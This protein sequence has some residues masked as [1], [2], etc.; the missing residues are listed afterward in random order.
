MR[1]EEREAVLVIFYLL[2]GDGPA[3]DGV[4]LLAIRTHLSAMH[5][6][7]LVAIR[8]V[9]S[10]ILEDRLY[11]ASN[12]LH[13]LVHSAERVICFVVIKFRNCPNWPPTRSCVTVLTRYC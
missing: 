4:A 1:S 9:P 8:A 10:D 6:S 2:R 7:L 5:V 12:A 13:F 11:V 3:L